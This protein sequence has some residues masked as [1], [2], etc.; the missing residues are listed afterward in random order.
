MQKTS[1]CDIFECPGRT[2]HLLMKTED[3]SS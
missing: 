2:I 3:M 1:N